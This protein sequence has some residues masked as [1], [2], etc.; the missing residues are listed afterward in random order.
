MVAV[1]NLRVITRSQLEQRVKP[2]AAVP[3][4]KPEDKVRLERD[5]LDALIDEALIDADAGRLGVEVGDQ[6]IET[7]LKEI[8]SRNELTLEQLLAAARQQGFEPQEYRAMLRQ[9]LTEA[10]WVRLRAALGGRSDGGEEDFA[11]WLSDERARLLQT[12]REKAAIEV[13]R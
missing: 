8:A 1:V 2:L 6:E 10:K 11:R 7:A 12:L 4:L 3:G 5:A 13:R 9:Q